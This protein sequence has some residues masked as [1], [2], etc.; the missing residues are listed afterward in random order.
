[1][2]QKA[3]YEVSSRSCPPAVTRSDEQQSLNDDPYDVEVS[4]STEA[5]LCQADE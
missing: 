5:D 4:L 3:H 2:T 1:M